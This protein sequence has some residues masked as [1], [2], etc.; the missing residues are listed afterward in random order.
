MA[1][2]NAEPSLQDAEAAL[3][4]GFEEDANSTGST[5]ATPANTGTSTEAQ[6]T[7]TDTGNTDATST[8]AEPPP[9]YVQLTETELETLRARGKLVEEIRDSTAKQFDTAFGKMGAFQ[10]VLNQLK[11]QLQRGNGLQPLEISK[12]DLAQLKE[13]YPDLAEVIAADLK[14]VFGKA[15]GGSV[16]QEQL[17]EIVQKRVDAAIPTLEA[18][19]IRKW[20]MK[21]LKKEV[22]DWEGVVKSKEFNEWYRQQPVEYQQGTRDS[23][24]AQVVID[25]INDFR[26]AQKASKEA[27]DKAAAAAAA[28]AAAE[29]RQ[30]EAATTRNQQL[31]AAVQPQGAGGHPSGPNPIDEFEAGFASG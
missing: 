25:V 3:N 28:K 11:E 1:D 16:N 31:A 9:K 10:Q 7:T 13:Q 27:A 8:P 4:A 18:Q 12:D 30:R 17:D 5:T 23:E 22:P 20:E 15:R 21:A 2:V 14:T 26:K 24:E 29:A 19:V 6:S